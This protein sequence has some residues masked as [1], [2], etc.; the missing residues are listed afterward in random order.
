MYVAIKSVTVSSSRW[1]GLGDEQILTQYPE[2]IHLHARR[3]SQPAT[4]PPIGAENCS[5]ISQ[6][7]H[8]S[9]Y[10]IDNQHTVDDA[11]RY[12]VR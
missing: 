7:A 10:Y 8:A 4:Y 3:R 6:T 9:V 1:S 5:S 11:A 2:A 12:M